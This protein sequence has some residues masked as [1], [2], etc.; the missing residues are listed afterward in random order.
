[1]KV[2]KNWTTWKSFWQHLM[3]A[4][5]FICKKKGHKADKCTEKKSGDKTS[6]RHSGDESSPKMTCCCNCQKPG[7]VSNDCWLK[8][9]KKHKRPNRNESAGEQGAAAAADDGNGS[10]VEFSMCAMCFPADPQMSNGP[11]ACIGDAG[12]TVH[13]MPHKNGIANVITDSKDDAVTMGNEQ[14][15]QATQIADIPGQACN[16]NGTQVNRAIM[17]DVAPVPN[18]KFNLFSVTKMMS[19]GWKLSGEKDKLTVTKDEDKINFDVAIPTSKGVICA[20]CVKTDTE[21]NGAMNPAWPSMPQ[22]FA[23]HRDEMPA[24]ERLHK[25]QR[26]LPPCSHEG[27]HPLNSLVGNPVCLLTVDMGCVTQPPHGYEINR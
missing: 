26:T 25:D 6:K 1:M 23:V 16:K 8:E 15:E 14:A 24:L 13:V 10:R 9:K 22:V 12:A 3:V 5:C 2:A 21:M 17:K 7:H 4:C 19:K 11:N 18:G 27:R 20:M